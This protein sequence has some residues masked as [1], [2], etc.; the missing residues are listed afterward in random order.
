MH[1]LKLDELPAYDA[2][3]AVPVRRGRLRGLR[4]LQAA[5]TRHL[6]LDLKR[7]KSETERRREGGREIGKERERERER[8]LCGSPS[9][10]GIPPGRP[11]AERVKAKAAS[12]SCE[13]SSRCQHPLPP[14]PEGA[15][16]LGPPHTPPQPHSLRHYVSMH[17]GVALYES[18]EPSR[19]SLRSELCCERQLP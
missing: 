9:R 3:G 17:R 15:P 12:A 8:A 4:S 19:P 11:G 6:R 7:R 1:A 16:T 5:S 18:R 13:P 2:G 10:Q 14:Q